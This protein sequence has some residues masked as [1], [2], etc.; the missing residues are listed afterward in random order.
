MP[1][2]AELRGLGRVFRQRGAGRGLQAAADVVRRW[3]SGGPPAGARRVTAGLWLGGEPSARGL[4]A[5]TAQG[6]TALVDLRP[7]ADGAAR[8]AGLAVLHLPTPEGEAPAP[9]KAG[10]D[11]VRAHVKAG[12][13]V[14]VHDWR[15]VGRAP[16]LVAATFVAAGDAPDDAWERVRRS[17]PWAAPTEAQARA[18]VAFA[19]TY[20]PAL[21]APLAE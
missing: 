13:R 8:E 11:F 9:L 16:T 10:V 15:G 2:L 4:A 3:A 19:R 14:Y 1:R 17:R 12:G 21:A 5:L 7:E 6:V 20:R 18:L